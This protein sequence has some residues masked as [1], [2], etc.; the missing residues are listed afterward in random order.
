MKTEPIQS[1]P[2][3]SWAEMSSIDDLMPSRYTWRHSLWRSGA[4]GSPI[5]RL[6]KVSEG[7]IG[8]ASLPIQ[9]PQEGFHCTQAKRILDI[10]MCQVCGMEWLLGNYQEAH[11]VGRG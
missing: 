10:S 4:P 9:D 11:H 2:P 3:Y 8:T 7:R 6:A 1:I 5:L